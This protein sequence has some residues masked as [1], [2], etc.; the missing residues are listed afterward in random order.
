MCD[1]PPS[2]DRVERACPGEIVPQARPRNDGSR[3]D[4]DRSIGWRPRPGVGAKT[5]V[6]CGDGDSR[7]QPLACLGEE[8]MGEADIPAEQP[9]P[10]APP[11][12]SAPHGDQGGTS[13]PEGPPPEGSP[14]P[15][16]LIGEV[17]PAGPAGS[18]GQV[19]GVGRVRDRATFNALRRSPHR[20]R[21]GPITVTFV[22]GDPVSPARVAYNV[23]RK[24]GG[25]VQRNRLR[26][27]LRAAAAQ[28]GELRPGAYLV[29]AAPDASALSFGELRAIVSE[30]LWTA[31][32]GSS[33][34]AEPARPPGVPPSPQSPS[35][36]EGS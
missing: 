22:L 31:A 21:R 10:S 1:E 33:T 14:S 8:A 32:W 36:P 9:P 18:G 24:V 26:R 16:R 29:G 2:D 30:A 6:S 28:A 5:M 13:H 11:R 25:A 20:S 27:R 23:G 4:G 3:K 12:V 19:L 7:S 17:E 34:R 35:Q 15:V